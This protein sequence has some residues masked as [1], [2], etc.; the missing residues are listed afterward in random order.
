MTSTYINLNTGQTREERTKSDREWDME[1]AVAPG[2]AQCRT[3]ACIAGGYVSLRFALPRC[4]L[5]VWT[6]AHRRGDNGCRARTAERFAAGR[7]RIKLQSGWLSS[8]QRG[9]FIASSRRVLCTGHSAQGKGGPSSRHHAQIFIALRSGRDPV[10]ASSCVHKIPA[11]PGA[12]AIE[13][14][15]GETRKTVSRALARG[16]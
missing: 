9:P 16:R 11:N 4:C 15:V 5:T 2:S 13:A 6:V 8:G 7:F 3:S 1:G 12:V 14:L 10:I